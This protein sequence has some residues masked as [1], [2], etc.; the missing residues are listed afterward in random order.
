MNDE[1]RKIIIDRVSEF[2][3]NKSNEYERVPVSPI[4]RWIIY[5]ILIP[6]VVVLML[7][8]VFFFAAFLALLAVA[9]VVI[10][11]RFWWFNRKFQNV[12]QQPDDLSR[13]TD[14]DQTII[15]EDAQIIEETETHR[16]K[17]K[18]Q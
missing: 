2:H 4:S 11:I 8:G 14:A 7:I 13:Q 10:G 9:V 15:I 17:Q 16:G 3:R 18:K 1:E 12:T 6:V 5:A